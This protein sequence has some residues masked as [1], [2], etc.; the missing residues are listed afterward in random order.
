MARARKTLKS[1]RSPEHRRLCALLNE[2]RRNAD[3]A[4]VEVGRRLGR[5]QS[6]VAKYEGGERRLDVIEFLAVCKAI[7]IDPVRIL[8]ALARPA[9][10]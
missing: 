10:R 4:Q 2:A 1:L 5:P 9:A 8:R 7:E 3:L 6:Y